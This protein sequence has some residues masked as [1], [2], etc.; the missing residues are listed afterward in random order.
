M[1]NLSE[2]NGRLIWF[3]GVAGAFSALPSESLDA[4]MKWIA[5]KLF[6]REIDFRIYTDDSYYFCQLYKRF[7]SRI[8]ADSAVGVET[9]SEAFCL[10]VDKY[11]REESK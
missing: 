8:I 2:S 5:P 4:C 3:A 6:E 7:T 11:L 1:I 10:A 9:A